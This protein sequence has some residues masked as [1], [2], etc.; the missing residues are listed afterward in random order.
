M[1]D[2]EVI[3]AGTGCVWC[4]AESVGYSKG[5]Y[6]SVTGEGD[7]Q[8]CYEMHTENIKNL[9]WLVLSECIVR[10]FSGRAIATRH[11][12]RKLCA[13]ASVKYPAEIISL[14]ADYIEVSEEYVKNI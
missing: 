10:M 14:A 7:I 6:V 8:F 9:E 4:G 5:R 13:C 11:S 2:Q 1:A 3:P 12:P